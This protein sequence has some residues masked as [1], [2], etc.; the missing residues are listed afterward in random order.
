[1]SKSKISNI[2]TIESVSSGWNSWT[3]IIGREIIE[4]IYLFLY[5][6]QSPWIRVDTSYIGIVIILL[7]MTLLYSYLLISIY[8]KFYYIGTLLS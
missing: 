1:M 5:Y 8:P 3:L 4:F 6:Y 2:F 7:H